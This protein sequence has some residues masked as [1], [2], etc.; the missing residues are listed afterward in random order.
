[1]E[2]TYNSTRNVLFAETLAMVLLMDSKLGVV[3]LKIPMNSLSNIKATRERKQQKQ[4]YNSL[5]ND[6]LNSR[7]VI[8]CTLEIGSLGH[9]LQTDALPTMKLL[10][11]EQNQKWQELPRPPQQNSNKLFI[12]HFQRGHI[13]T[14]TLTILPRPFISHLS[15]IISVSYLDLVLM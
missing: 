13:L 15:H 6:I 14:C 2:N 4:L 7:N 5:F 3:E 8:Y 12:P 10:F 11:P 9:F 1:M